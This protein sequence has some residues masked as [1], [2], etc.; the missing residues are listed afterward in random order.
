MNE[1]SLR[2]GEW[3]PHIVVGG[4]LLLLLVHLLMRRTRQPARSQYLGEWGM[5]AALLLAGLSLGPS[6]LRVPLLRPQSPSGV[7]RQP[8]LHRDALASLRY[9]LA[10]EHAACLIRA[11]EE[12]D[13]VLDERNEP[14]SAHW[15]EVS[16]SGDGAVRAL[17]LPIAEPSLGAI[18]EVP[19][20][21][22]LLTSA[23]RWVEDAKD[24]LPW[25]GLAYAVVAVV[26]LGRWLVGYLALW[27][28]L[29]TA[30]PAPGTALRLFRRMTGR[31]HRPRLLVSA[32]IR[33]PLSCGLFRPT[34]VIPPALCQPGRE[35]TLRWVFAH[36]LTH[37][38]RH[39]AWSCLLF[40]LGQAVYFY[41]P[42]FW[43]LRR[44]VRL[45][46]EYIADA[47]A[48]QE[49]DYP[50]DYA[51]FLLSLTSA[52]AVPL[53]ATGVLGN[54]SDLFRRVTMLL[55]N[56]AHVE[57][58]CPRW[59]SLATAGVLLALAVVFRGWDCGHRPPHGPTPTC[60]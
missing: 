35:G 17:A 28:L 18:G 51:E 32:Q 11:D 46:Q 60:F 48:V 20:R 39:D 9:P 41:L 47:A 57:R 6:W 16:S 52:P 21:S 30:G 24:F 8:I 37:L 34:V 59:W 45:C 49:A 14:Q 13:A 44:Q 1:T 15:L 50:E 4:G 7:E 5:A 26:L 10:E 53:S 27:H 19:S 58:G 22:L 12:Q 55:Q 56:S 36:E 3:L 43:W 31:P 33:A 38:Q 23:A 25:L 2:S 40:G 54:S 42:W 29:R